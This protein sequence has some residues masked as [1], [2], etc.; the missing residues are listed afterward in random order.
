M[1]VRGGYND[2]R[3]VGWEKLGWW[4]VEDTMIRGLLGGRSW[5][6]SCE[7]RAS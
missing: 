1:V 4:Y 5:D 7:L 3:F 6:G 2:S